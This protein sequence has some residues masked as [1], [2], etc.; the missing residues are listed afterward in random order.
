[1]TITAA[2]TVIDSKSISGG[3]LFIKAKGV[4]IKNSKIVGLIDNEAPNDVTIQDTEIDGGQ[5]QVAA[6]TQDNVTLIRDN[7]HGSRQSITCGTNCFISDSWL[8]GQYNKP[9]GGWH[10]NG[11]ISNGGNNVVIRHNTLACDAKYDAPSDGGCTGPAAIFAD[12]DPVYNVTFDQNLFVAGPGAWCLYAGDDPGKAFAGNAKNA[13]GIVITNNVFQRGSN[14]K[15]ASFGAVT[16][17]KSGGAGNVFSGNTWDD[18][19][20][21]TP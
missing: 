9:G 2:N 18:A 17:Y 1:M 20:V 6:V 11:F 13:T 15:C 8:H 10:V 21:V 14:R 7:I 4:V 5:N 19:S 12:F 3:T 16:S